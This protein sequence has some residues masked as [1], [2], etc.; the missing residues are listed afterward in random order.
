LPSGLNATLNGVPRE[1]VATRFPVAAFQIAAPT[2]PPAVA[3][4]VPSLLKTAV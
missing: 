4:R 2:W 3:M 1:N